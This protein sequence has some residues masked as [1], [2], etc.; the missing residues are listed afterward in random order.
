MVTF[1]GLATAWA[2]PTAAPIATVLIAR[3]AAMATNVRLRGDCVK[4]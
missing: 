3:A 4:I 2:G 1:T